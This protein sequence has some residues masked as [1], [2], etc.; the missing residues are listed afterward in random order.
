M[1]CLL[2]TQI[3]QLYCYECNDFI[4]A[5]SW[6]MVGKLV[7]SEQELLMCSVVS[8]AKEERKNYDTVC[9]DL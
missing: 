4:K 2:N 9:K 7:S 3:G 8:C 5:C 6:L 1:Q